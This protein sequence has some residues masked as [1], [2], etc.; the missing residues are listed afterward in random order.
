VGAGRS[1]PLGDVSGGLPLRACLD[2]VPKDIEARLVG[3]TGQS[4][5]GVLSFHSCKTVELM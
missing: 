4:V 1:N 3:K 5:D 2:K